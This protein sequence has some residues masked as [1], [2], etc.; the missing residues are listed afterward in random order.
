MEL[1][2][3]SFLKATGLAL[4]G[5]MVYGLSEQSSTFAFADDAADDDWKLMNTEE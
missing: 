1:T 2:R 4:A 5:S 3:R